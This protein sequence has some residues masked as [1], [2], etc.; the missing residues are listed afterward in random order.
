MAYIARALYYL[1]HTLPHSPNYC[2]LNGKG[3][4]LWAFFGFN[5][6]KKLGAPQHRTHG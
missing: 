4:S 2:V 3:N 1:L 5:I 6:P